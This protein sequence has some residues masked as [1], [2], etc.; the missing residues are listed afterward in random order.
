MTGLTHNPICDGDLA[1]LRTEGANEGDQSTPVIKP[2]V[3]SPHVEAKTCDEGGDRAENPRY[4][5]EEMRITFAA[6]CEHVLLMFTW[7]WGVS[8]LGA[9]EVGF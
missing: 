5:C 3:F 8:K 2:P 9:M 4:D 6:A 1:S 7:S